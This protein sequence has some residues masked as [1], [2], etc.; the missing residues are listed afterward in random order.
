MRGLPLGPAFASAFL[1]VL[2]LFAQGPDEY[3]LEQVLSAESMLG[4]S[5]DGRGVEPIP[6][7]L[8]Q[9]LRTLAVLRKAFEESSSD[10]EWAGKRGMEP[11]EWEDLEGS[12]RHAKVRALVEAEYR[13]AI[14]AI[15]S[16]SGWTVS[17]IGVGSGEACRM[18]PEVRRDWKKW[19]REA[20]AL[21]GTL[22]TTYPYGFQ[23][24]GE[25]HLETLAEI[26]QRAAA[27]LAELEMADKECAYGTKRLSE[28]GDKAVG[29]AGRSFSGDLDAAGLNRS[30]DNLH[31]SGGVGAAV[32]G[33]L[34]PKAPPAAPDGPK[35]A[36]LRTKE[37][38]PVETFE[39]LTQGVEFKGPA[40]VKD[41]LGV[42][43]DNPKKQ[44]FDQALRHVYDI[45]EGRQ[46]LRDIQALRAEMGRR[47]SENAAERKK[48]LPALKAGLAAAEAKL[49]A[50]E[51]ENASGRTV[52]PRGSKG[53][54]R[55]RSDD[56]LKPYRVVKECPKGHPL[57]V[58]DWPKPGDM[59][60][61]GMDLVAA[62]KRSK[63]EVEMAAV[64][65]G[66]GEGGSKPSIGVDIGKPR[67][68][69]GGSAD[70]VWQIWKEPDGRLRHVNVLNV[71]EEF[72]KD[73]N[74]SRPVDKVMI[75]E[76]RH[77]A[78]QAVFISEHESGVRWMLG[79]DRAYLSESRAIMEQQP[80]M[81][82]EKRSEAVEA[83]KARE[84]VNVLRDPASD[85][86]SRIASPL[87]LWHVGH[88]DLEDPEAALRGRLSQAYG[89]L[90]FADETRRRQVADEIDRDD[91]LL[92]ALESARPTSRG[93]EIPDQVA[94]KARFMALAERTPVAQ[95]WLSDLRKFAAAV[96]SPDEAPKWKARYEA[97]EDR[98]WEEVGDFVA[99]YRS[100]LPRIEAE[101][102]ES[103]EGGGGGGGVDPA[104]E[105]APAPARRR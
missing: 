23:L 84:V 15:E 67:P 18:S 65:I 26:D 74:P 10:P 13:G 44:V 11:G 93:G 35:P 86:L 89:M 30:F 14:L 38:P 95:A 72:M 49:A 76:L 27:H 4:P 69:T 77:V 46:V 90:R 81:R 20:G 66:A 57:E 53:R 45:P 28:R 1:C 47:F 60:C 3:G 94:E 17:M 88:V 80:A 40:K 61:K 87:Y 97:L 9:D 82:R 64:V 55:V 34:G 22:G 39:S 8:P 62:V 70:H 25:P 85:R 91:Q 73:G 24:L 71:S 48:E 101:A 59:G 41:S 103:F 68:L 50:F 104:P 54:I 12:A 79:E 36:G 52:P 102:L 98:Y 37:P 96:R 5:I 51:K 83:M 42:M 31:A 32:A 92:K 21:R 56:P 100:E 33:R 58:T 19:M 7:A 2:P 75:H 6:Y 78:D 105:G 29:E 43:V 99:R 16:Y 63:G